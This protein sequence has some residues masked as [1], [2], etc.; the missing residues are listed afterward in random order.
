MPSAIIAKNFRDLTK[1]VGW[2]QYKGQCAA[3]VQ[4]YGCNLTSYWKEGAAV[5]GNQLIK[6]GTCVAT[7]ENGVYPN[8][9]SGNHAAIYISQSA[10]G[11]TVYDQWTGRDPGARTM[12]FLTGRT[13]PSNNGN[14]LSVILTT[15]STGEAGFADAVLAADPKMSA[16]TLA[17]IAA[18]KDPAMKSLLKRV[19][20]DER[21]STTEAGE[22]SRYVLNNRKNMKGYF[23]LLTILAGVRTIDPAGRHIIETTLRHCV[24]ASALPKTNSWP[25]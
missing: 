5:K 2:G 12:Q 25:W 18:M 20:G 19:L 15:P 8:R 10:A 6:E 7:F 1:P 24:A 9:S 11:I 16:A 21:L 22:I 13:N 4:Y 17:V 14:C 23:E 3:L